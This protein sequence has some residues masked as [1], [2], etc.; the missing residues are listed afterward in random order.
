M[1]ARAFWTGG[2]VGCLVSLILSAFVDGYPP[3]YMWV[4]GACICSAVSELVMRKN[5]SDA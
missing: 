2:T 5:G 1:K 4:S 3:W